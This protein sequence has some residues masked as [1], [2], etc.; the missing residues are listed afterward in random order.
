MS[1]RLNLSNRDIAFL[2]ILTAIPVLGYQFGMG[3]Q[4]EQFPIIE[5][6]R[7]PNFIVGDFYTDSAVRFGPRFYYSWFVSFLTHI[8]PLAVVIFLLTCAVNFG[9]GL[10]TFQAVR[11]RLEGSPT[12]S[13][14]AAALAIANS[15]FAL[16]LAGYLRFESFQPASIAIPLSFAGFIW[17]AEGRRYLAAGAFFVASLS[18]PLI[19]P[20]IAL[21]AYGSCALSDLVERKG[22]RELLAYIRPACC[23]RPCSSLPGCF[24]TSRAKTCGCRPKNSSRS[25]R[26]SGPRTI[27][28]GR[29]FRCRTIARSPHFSRRS[30]SSPISFGKPAKSRCAIVCCSRQASS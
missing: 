17:L 2:V 20:E 6:L 24:P 22:V 28:S 19:G 29:R 23:L 3:N 26:H 13:A 15:S 7:D 30:R 18:H 25:S 8:A 16:G 10:V 11:K 14:I 9:L 1:T 12:G 21:V 4:V 27:T 5:R